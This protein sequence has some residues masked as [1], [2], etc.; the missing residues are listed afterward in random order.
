MKKL[1]QGKAHPMMGM[2]EKEAM[3]KEAQELRVF[4]GKGGGLFRDRV[5]GSGFHQSIRRAGRNR[6]AGGT[7]ADQLCGACGYALPEELCPV[8]TGTEGTRGASFKGGN[9]KGICEE[10]EPGKGQSHRSQLC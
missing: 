4:K 3:R 9:R 1:V 8:G 10:L 2:E 5:G 7:S 6:T